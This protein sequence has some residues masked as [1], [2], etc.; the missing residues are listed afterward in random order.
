MEGLA[1]QKVAVV[2]KL[3]R[4]EITRK[5]SISYFISIK[6]SLHQNFIMKL[7]INILITSAVV[8]FLA[9][10][11]SPHVAINSF[12]TAII[13]A[14]VLA[15]LNFLLKPVL[16][17]LTLPIT[18]ITLGLFLLV[19]NVIIILV[20]DKF[21]P[22]IKIESFLWAFVFGLILSVVTSILNKAN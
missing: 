5:E 13:F 16:V 20:A 12:Q 17:I 22:G 1:I 2:K 4:G 18:I 6:H 14:I 11:L 9:K 21:V 10:L 8:Y 3:R 19:I 15:V 7:I